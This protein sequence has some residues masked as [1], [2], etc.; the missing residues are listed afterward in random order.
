MLRQAWSYGDLFLTTKRLVWIRQRFAFPFARKLLEIPLVD[1]VGWSTESA[2]WWK[3][4]RLIRSIDR[5]VRLRTTSGTF[6]FI[7]MYSG[8]DADDWVEALETVMAEAR[9]APR[10]PA[11]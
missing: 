7:P 6:Q 5:M 8:K 9:R 11:P 4:W 3:R 2:P 10:G 1:I